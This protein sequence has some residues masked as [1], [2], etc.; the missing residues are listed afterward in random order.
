MFFLAATMLHSYNTFSPEI[1]FLKNCPHRF[2][3]VGLNK[4]KSKTVTGFSDSK[5]C[6]TIAVKLLVSPSNLNLPNPSKCFWKTQK[7]RCHRIQTRLK[8]LRRLRRATNKLDNYGKS[9]FSEIKIFLV[10]NSNKLC[11]LFPRF[12]LVVFFSK[13]TLLQWETTYGT[14]PGPS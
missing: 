2:F 11:V 6:F 13:T 5:F 3:S 1:H 12:N 9:C 14:W 10:G 4:Y 7:S 8:S